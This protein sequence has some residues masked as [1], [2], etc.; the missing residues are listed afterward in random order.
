MSGKDSFDRGVHSS[1]HS[2]NWAFSLDNLIIYIVPENDGRGTAYV[3]G[4]TS[5]RLS[6]TPCPL[7]GSPRE[8][9]LS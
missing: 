4:L 3:R 8:R 5:W 7:P 6:G 9:P 2:L 1:S